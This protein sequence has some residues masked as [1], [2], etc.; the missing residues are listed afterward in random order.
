MSRYFRTYFPF[1][2]SKILE[3]FQ[4]RMNVVLWFIAE[5]LFMFV[6]FFLWKAIYET[7]GNPVMIKG[8]TMED[9]LIYILLAHIIGFLTFDNISYQIGFDIK[10]GKIA[11]YLIKP[12][13]YRV[14]LLFISLGTFLGYLMVLLIP[15]LIVLF[16]MNKFYNL[17]FTVK[18]SD[19]AIAFA[20]LIL[21]KVTQFMFKVFIGLFSFKLTEI[22]GLIWLMDSLTHFLTGSLIPIALFPDLLKQI[23]IYLPFAGLIYTPAMIVLGKLPVEALY[24]AFII[25][26]IWLIIFTIAVE[27]LWNRMI[28]RLV[29][30]GG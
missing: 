7:P 3:L 11:N 13:S 10:E 19:I 27:L 18:L 30:L 28:K 9:M 5:G 17:G 25:Q 2:K 6:Y 1:A 29:I 16:T 15:N 22:H 14:T 23:T 20:L 21:A 24:S 8:F 4:Y 26:F 12:I